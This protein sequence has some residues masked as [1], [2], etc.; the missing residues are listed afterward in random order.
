MENMKL[1][2]WNLKIGCRDYDWDGSF[3]IDDD[4]SKNAVEGMEYDAQ[5]YGETRVYSGK[6]LIISKRE[7]AHRTVYKFKGI[8][9]IPILVNA[10]EAD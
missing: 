7:L 9:K 6:I 10:D 4:N 5:F 1:V 3:E 8:S 2:E